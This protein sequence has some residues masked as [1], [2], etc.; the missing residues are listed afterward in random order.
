MRATKT[1]LVV[2][3]VVGAMTAAACGQQSASPARPP[4]DNANA[5]Y[6]L[7]YAIAEIENGKKV[8]TRTYTLLTD[9][10]GTA[11]MHMGLRVPLS[12][13][14][15]PI[16]MDVGLRLDCKV[17]PRQGNDVWLSTRFEVSSLVDQQQTVSGA[18]PVR[19]VEYSMP[20]VVT[21]GKSTVLAAG[22]DLGSQ[23]HFELSVTVTKLK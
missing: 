18:L 4:E 14:K 16:Y 5:A 22:D 6:R 12:A 23:K 19:N 8:N 10:G 17:R 7:D 9:E 13:E 3:V 11:N 21:V 15:G 20:T 1:M 2:L